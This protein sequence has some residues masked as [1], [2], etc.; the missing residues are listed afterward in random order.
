MDITGYDSNSTG[1]YHVITTAAKCRRN[2]LRNSKKHKR[3][4][5]NLCMQKAL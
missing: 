4:K 2:I 1:S 5:K 3:R